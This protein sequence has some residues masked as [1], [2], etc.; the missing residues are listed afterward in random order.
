MGID[1]Q[2]D[3]VKAEAKYQALIQECKAEEANLD[4]INTDRQ[5]Q[6]ELKKAQA[7]EALGGGHNTKIVVSGSSGETLINK[8]FDLSK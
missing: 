8:I 3:K 6:Y 1:A 4:A 5:H 7:Y 2:T